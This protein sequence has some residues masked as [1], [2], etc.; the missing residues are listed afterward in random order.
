MTVPTSPGGYLAPAD[1]ADL[2]KI[3]VRAACNVMR[4]AGAFELCGSWRVRADVLDAWLARQ[5]VGAASRGAAGSAL[6]STPPRV[7]AALHALHALHATATKG[8]R[9][10]QPRR[11]RK[12][13]P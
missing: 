10:P 4:K 6:K 9:H 8:M 1:V 3:G 7:P 2:L 11:R 5:S 13:T 12:A